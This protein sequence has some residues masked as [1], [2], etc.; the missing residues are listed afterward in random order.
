MGHF[1]RLIL[2]LSNILTTQKRPNGRKQAPPNTRQLSQQAFHQC[3]HHK[4]GLA[5]DKG[6]LY[7]ARRLSVY[8]YPRTK[9]LWRSSIPYHPI[10]EVKLR[11]SFPRWRRCPSLSG[12]MHRFPGEQ[13]AP[14][15][16]QYCLKA[17]RA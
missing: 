15:G 4:E 10:L 8:S 6:T 9:Q 1:E 13:S 16:T 14:C 3:I 11:S 7:Y 2:S 17:H 12:A 5:G